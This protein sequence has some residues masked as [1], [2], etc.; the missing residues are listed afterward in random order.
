[1]TDL[2]RYAADLADQL[3]DRALPPV[4]KW[5]PDRCGEIDLVIRSDGVW[6]HE[7][8]P[9][10]RAKLVRLLSTVIRKDGD[11]YFFVTPAEKLRFIVE[12]A[13]FIAVM[14]RSEQVPGTRESTPDHLVFTTN[15]ADE[16]VAGP[17][18][19]IEMREQAGRNDLAPYIHVRGG[20]EA[21]LARPVFY[22]LVGLGEIRDVGGARQFGVASGEAFFAL[23]PEGD[24]YCE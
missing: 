2:I 23:A 13:P 5:N 16:I 18:H 11:E 20:L 19:A 9:I 22:D 8:A 15:L 12:D 10:K 3:S 14:M 6:L 4:E 7:G 1:M 24:V 21:R 17:G